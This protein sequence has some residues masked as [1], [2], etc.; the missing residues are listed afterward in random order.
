MKKNNDI[1]FFESF[2]QFPSLVHGFSTRA[3]GNMNPAES[4]SQEAVNVF[5]KAIG[6]DA[7][8]L[9]RME[10]THGKTVIWVSQKDTATII[11]EVDG[12]LTD[13]EN[14]FLGVK[15]ADCVPL[16]LYDPKKNIVG[17][18]HAG[19]R[20]LFKE[21]IPEAIAQ[22]KTRGSNPA[23]IIAGIGPCMGVCCYDIAPDHRDKL[24]KKFPAW[25]EFI[26]TRAA[27]YFLN[28]SAI[29]SAQLLAAGVTN[30]HIESGDYCTMD[31]S[32][33]YSYRRE[34]EESGRMIG[35]I[36]LQSS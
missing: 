29:A 3:F 28:L 17:A 31:H 27:K 4:H 13:K 30:E 26:E 12:L 23:D 18:V 8:K 6:I 33:V 16:L 21:I 10:Q 22:M 24:L 25:E 34:G 7:Q 2:V 11:P 32:D 36:G 20:G 9:V 35:I 19:W 5:T 14:V 1:L 15:V